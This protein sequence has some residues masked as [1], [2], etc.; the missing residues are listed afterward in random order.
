MGAGCKINYLGLFH[1]KISGEGSW[2]ANFSSTI[3]PRFAKTISLGPGAS[4][5]ENTVIN[6]TF[7][8]L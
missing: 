7:N 5:G 6:F 3:S 8:P 4:I 2:S 1:L